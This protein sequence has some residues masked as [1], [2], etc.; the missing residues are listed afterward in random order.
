MRDILIKILKTSKTKKRILDSL[1][2]EPMFIREIS[3]KLN[4]YPS[5]ILKHLKFLE[6]KNIL[7]SHRIGKQKFYR[8]TKNG[9]KLV[10]SF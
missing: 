9:K 2:E 4:I 6:E 7:E 5:S 3:R 10:N 1:L 8:L